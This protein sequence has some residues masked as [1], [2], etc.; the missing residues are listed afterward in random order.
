MDLIWQGNRLLVPG[1]NLH[2]ISV[3]PPVGPINRL[4]SW[5]NES[6]NTFSSVG[7]SINTMIEPAGG[8][9]GR[10]VSNSYPII[11]YGFTPGQWGTV[12]FQYYLTLNSGDI[13]VECYVNGSFQGQTHSGYI[14]P[15]VYQAGYII[16]ESGNVT[17][18]FVNYTN[19]G[20]NCSATNCQMFITDGTP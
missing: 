20:V 10:C 9:Y 3:P 2:I 4:T 11:S 16:F 8:T 15:G 7:N 6:F 18:K 14:N 17:F 12:N 13:A 1:S 5:T 19:T